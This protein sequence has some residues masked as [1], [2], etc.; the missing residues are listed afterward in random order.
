MSEQKS[1]QD[2][3]LMEEELLDKLNLILSN[4]TE[5][6]LLDMLAAASDPE[7]IRRLIQILINPGTMK[8]V[9]NI[10]VLL[11]QLGDISKTLSEPVEPIS[12]FTFIRRLRDKDASKGLAR[13][14][15]IL[16]ILGK[17]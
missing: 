14:L 16:K 8:L 10:D 13:L 5:S 1:I 15:A 2:T 7:A 12:L 3:M 6:G 9:D 4:I 17:E 11:N